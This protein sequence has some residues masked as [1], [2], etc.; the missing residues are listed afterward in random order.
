MAISCWQPLLWLSVSNHSQI[1]TSTLD[2]CKKN[3]NEPTDIPQHVPT[4]PRVHPPTSDSTGRC[5][6]GTEVSHRGDGVRLHRSPGEMVPNSS[7]GKRERNGTTTPHVGI[8]FQM[9]GACSNMYQLLVGT[10]NVPTSKLEHVG[11]PN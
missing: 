6:P 1:Y 4:P 5:V 10:P 3:H 2:I 7:N 9:F 11:T 8:I